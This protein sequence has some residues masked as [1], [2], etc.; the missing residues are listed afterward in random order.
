[1]EPISAAALKGSLS[2]SL[3]EELNYVNAPLIANVASASPKTV[4]EVTDYVNTLFVGVRT[5]S[6]SMRWRVL[7]WEL[8]RCGSSVS[9]DTGSKRC[10]R[11]T[12]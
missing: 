3:G 11:A 2:A 4:R 7:R 8:R 1:M 6:A 10:L 12:S 9:M 5:A